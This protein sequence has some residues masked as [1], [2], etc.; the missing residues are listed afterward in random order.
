[1]LSITCEDS[2]YKQNLWI[3]LMCSF[4]ASFQFYAKHVFADKVVLYNPNTYVNHLSMV[5]T[6][7]PLF[8]TSIICESTALYPFRQMEISQMRWRM[9]QKTPAAIGNMGMQ[10]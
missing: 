9:L 2:G 1:M 7:L 5:I 6:P 10:P 4:I 3:I 8:F